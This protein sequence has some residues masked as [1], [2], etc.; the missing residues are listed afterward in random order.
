MMQANPF[1]SIYLNQDDVF[2]DYGFHSQDISYTKISN[3]ITSSKFDV[4]LVTELIIRT[5]VVLARQG[6]KGTE[7]EKKKREKKVNPAVNF[8]MATITWCKRTRSFPHQ[9]VVST[10]SF[11]HAWLLKT[12][13]VP[14][15]VSQYATANNTRL[16]LAKG[17]QEYHSLYFFSL[18]S[19]L[20][21][22]QGDRNFSGESLAI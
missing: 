14:R 21:G 16:G 22:E 17:K 11:D 10:A 19:F 5:S 13:I 1:R 12:G 7:G 9:H 6:E 8:S 18:Y 20:T 15:A 4:V 3:L 2:S